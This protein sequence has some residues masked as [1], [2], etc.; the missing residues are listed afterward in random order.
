MR[1]AECGMAFATLDWTLSFHH[2]AF[3][4]PHSSSA[5]RR[6]GRPSAALRR[7][8]RAKRRRLLGERGGVGRGEALSAENTGVTKG[9]H[10]ATPAPLQLQA[11]P[12]SFQT[13]LKDQ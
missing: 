8:Q 9:H 7:D 4:I 10:R 12:T 1:N 5:L 11:Q 13:S 6:H 3:T 2:A